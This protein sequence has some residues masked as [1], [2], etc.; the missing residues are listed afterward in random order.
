MFILVIKWTCPSSTFSEVVF[1]FSLPGER[2]AWVPLKTNKRVYLKFRRQVAGSFDLLL[3]IWSICP[4][5]SLTKRPYPF[6]NIRGEIMRPPPSPKGRKKRLIETTYN[7]RKRIFST[8]IC[9]LLNKKI[10][11]LIFTIFFL[12]D[13]K[14]NTYLLDVSVYI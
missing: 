8:K 3:T 1:L 4:P 9:V 14:N 7:G 10:I 12:Q 2:L 11:N 6:Q 5:P 13:L